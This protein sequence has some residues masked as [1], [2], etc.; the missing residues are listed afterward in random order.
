[1]VLGSCWPRLVTSSSRTGVLWAVL[2]EWAGL[3]MS[4]GP[5]PG[6]EGVLEVRRLWS[7]KMGFGGSA[8][9]EVMVLRQVGWKQR[10]QRPEGVLLGPRTSGGVVSAG[11]GR[12]QPG[13]SL[14]EACQLRWASVH[15]WKI[16]PH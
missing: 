10:R 5:M 14:A 8:G 13:K 9:L 6:V 2:P 16:R 11:P 3:G 12:E 1:M 7:K 15:R 4:R